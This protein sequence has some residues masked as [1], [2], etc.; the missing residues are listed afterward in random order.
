MSDLKQ[1]INERIE[2]LRPK[3]QDTTR[4]NPLI[5]NRLRATSASFLRIVDEI[6]QNIFDSISNER[7][8]GMKLV[9]LPPTDIDPIDEETKEFRNAFLNAQATDE[10]YAKK[11]EKLDFELDEK[12]YDKQEKIERELKDKIRELLELPPRPSGDQLSDLFNHAKAHDINPSSSLPQPGAIDKDGRYTDDE[13]QTLLLPKTFQ[14]RMS[15][16]LS[17]IKLYQEEKGLDV[18]FIVLGYLT[19]SLPNTEG[20]EDFKS[21]LLL[22]PVELT[23]LKSKEGD[24]FRVTKRDEIVLNPTLVHKLT[25]DVGIDFSSVNE[26]VNQESF[27]VEEVFSSVQELQPKNMRWNVRREA[28][29]GV[30]PYR[31]IEQFNDL[32]TANLDFSDFPIL[33]ELMLGRDGDSNASSSFDSSDV[34]GAT[35][36][37]L[38]PHL[39]LDADS[40]QFISL[41]KV[42]NGENVALEGLL[43]QVKVKLS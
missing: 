20:D 25:T 17:K 23:K 33:S 12:A 28:S 32:D 36:E 11:L 27:Q 37:R 42:A 22:M 7:S 14:S 3:L 10:D 16:I 30:Y 19:W 15:R 21:P 38:V 39:V 4:R 5:N 8:N 29:F 9:P 34:E 1:L 6:P 31:G 41:M 18:A 2:A 26:T 24:S 40:S 43:V 13:L 35:A